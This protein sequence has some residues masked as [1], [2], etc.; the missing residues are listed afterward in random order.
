M[1]FEDQSERITEGMAVI[2]CLKTC[3]PRAGV[4][5]RFPGFRNLRVLQMHVIKKYFSLCTASVT[6]RIVPS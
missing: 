4:I 1:G 5:E 2:S 3:V 6:F